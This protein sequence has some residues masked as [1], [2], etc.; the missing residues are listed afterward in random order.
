VKKLLVLLPAALF[1]CGCG[2][3]Q[4]TQLSKKTPKSTII[5]APTR[6]PGKPANQSTLKK[7]EQKKQ[8]IVIN[9]VLPASR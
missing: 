7:G 3:T 1:L 6:S 4:W 2:A 9:C 8:E 5:N